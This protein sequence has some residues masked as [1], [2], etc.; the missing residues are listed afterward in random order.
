M[1]DFLNFGFSA[2]TFNVGCCISN[3]SSTVLGLT[4]NRENTPVIYCSKAFS[5]LKI[6]IFDTF[7]FFFFC[8]G[9]AYPLA[10]FL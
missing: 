10:T 5:F 8:A 1:F 9:V 6:M 7:I 3:T 2:T 4:P